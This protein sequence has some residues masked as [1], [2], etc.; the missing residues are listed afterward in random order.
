MS[1]L[2]LHLS[3]VMIFFVSLQI[4]LTSKRDFY[5]KLPDKQFLHFQY[6]FLLLFHKML[7]ISE[8][9]RHTDSLQTFVE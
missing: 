2:R 8:H 3:S 9:S 5:P 4:S 6:F 1:Y 7:M